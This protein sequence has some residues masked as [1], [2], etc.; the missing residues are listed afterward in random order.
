MGIEVGV[1]DWGDFT[2][3]GVEGLAN[4]MW[5]IWSASERRGVRH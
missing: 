3:D 4:D 1:V 2:G 5:A